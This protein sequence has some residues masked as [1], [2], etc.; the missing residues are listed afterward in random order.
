MIDKILKIAKENPEGFTVTKDLEFV[1]SGFVVAY[2][3][4]Q[5]S[6]GIDGLKKVIEFAF[7]NDTEIGGWKEKKLFYFDASKVYETKE[8]ATKKAIENNQIA[9]FDLNN[10]EVIFI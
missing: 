3:E 10:L 7:K 1:K 2:S 5:N 8:E 9:F 4:T 6:F